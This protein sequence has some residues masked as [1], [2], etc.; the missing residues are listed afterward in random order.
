[1]ADEIVESGVDAPIA[2]TKYRV[3]PLL[4]D[5][6]NR[7][8]SDAPPELQ[9]DLQHAITSGYRD[10]EQQMKAYLHHLAG[11]G[12]AAKPGHSWH[13]RDH[14]MA[15]DWNNITPRAWGYLKDHAIDYG[16]GFPLG[17]R[18]PFHMQPVESYTGSKKGIGGTDISSPL[19]L[20]EKY[21][22]G[23][24]NILQQTGA[25][26]S[27]ASGYW[28]I[29]DTNWRAYGPKLGIDTD[30]Y[31]TAMSAPRDLQAK[32]AQTMYDE[33]GFGDWAP[34]NSKLAAAIKRGEVGDDKTDLPDVDVRAAKPPDLPQVPLAQRTQLG[35][36]VTSPVQLTPPPKVRPLHAPHAVRAPNLA[37]TYSGGL[38]RILSGR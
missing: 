36:I 15:V 13:E 23:G 34:Y 37:S 27:T 24:R 21:E 20:I 1:M 31:P 35:Q 5:R 6:V 11:G 25:T 18:D 29:T 32:V 19:S 33:H 30:Q 38:R 16:L 14:G 28:Q 10:H 3:N 2:G 9:P 4:A 8:I 12:L 22:S 7:L 17:S 26:N